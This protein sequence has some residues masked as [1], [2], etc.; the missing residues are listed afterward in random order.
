MS[1]IGPNLGL[2]I[3]VIGS[4]MMDDQRRAEIL[5]RLSREMFLDDRYKN[6]YQTISEMV[7]SGHHIDYATVCADL[8]RHGKA[9]LNEV[10]AESIEKTPCL[11]KG[12]EYAADLAKLSLHRRLYAALTKTA[13]EILAGEI[14]EVSASSIFDRVAKAAGLIESER[15]FIP[16]S[17][18]IDTF[19]V[20]AHDRKDGDPGLPETGIYDF[21]RAIQIF[22]PSTFTVV[23]ARPA[24]GK[25]TLMRQ[26]VM[27]SAKR[28]PV[29]VF[30]LEES[31]EVVRDKMLCA[32]AKVEYAKWYQGFSTKEE[33]TRLLIATGALESLPIVFHGGYSCDAARVKLAIRSMTEQ[34]KKPIAVFV[35]HLQ[36]M[37]HGKAESR[38]Q[39]VG[40]TTRELRL[41]S[42]EFNVPIILLCQMNRGIDNR[43]SDDKR[44]RLSDLRESGNIEAN[45]VNVVFLWRESTRPEESGNVTVSIA[46]H[47]DGP[48]SDLELVLLKA[49]GVF[50][51]K[52]FGRP[53]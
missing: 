6:L 20:E 7:V 50:G 8:Q 39:A 12:L 48:T 23:A 25:S 31:N 35:D 4:L 17:E 51:G 32:L 18:L 24:V 14:A 52:S 3:C 11:D 49:V 36:L 19:D 13:S 33:K 29:L 16:A 44:P 40:D 41:A 5:M 30:S 22:K 34:G 15:L 27:E 38:D 10:L 2:E 28:G 47:R 37:R 26:A 45:A 53:A 9:S 42:L 21:D 43:G 1:S 46:K